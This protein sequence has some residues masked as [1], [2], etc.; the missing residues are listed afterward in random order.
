MLWRASPLILLSMLLCGRADLGGLSRSVKYVTKNVITSDWADSQ[1]AI[2]RSAGVA[3]KVNLGGCITSHL[4][5]ITLHTLALKP[6]GDVTRN[7]NKDTSGSKKELHL[8][9]TL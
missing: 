5:Q 9:K 2:E 4:W 6:S 3:L 8:L 1:R 7:S